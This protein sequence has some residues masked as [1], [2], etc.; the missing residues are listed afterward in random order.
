MER[1]SLSL[2]DKA[3]L[4]LEGSTIHSQIP[5]YLGSDTK[6]HCHHQDSDESG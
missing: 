5:I 3:G 6:Y 4:V 2:C 1:S